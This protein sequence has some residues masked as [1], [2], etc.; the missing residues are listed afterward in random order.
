VGLSL[1]VGYHKQM[2]TYLDQNALIELGVKGRRAEFRM[3]LDAAIKSV[4]DE[5]CTYGEP[6]ASV[7][8]D[9]FAFHKIRFIIYPQGYGEKSKGDLMSCGIRSAYGEPLN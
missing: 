2:L 7:A 4:T 5:N 3:K 8:I 6:D 1:L 9:Q